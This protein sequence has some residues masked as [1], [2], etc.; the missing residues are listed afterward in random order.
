MVDEGKRRDAAITAETEWD[1]AVW[2]AIVIAKDLGT[3]E[4]LLRG[5]SVPAERIDLRQARRFGR[6]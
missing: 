2:R 3:C 4:A 1:R 5:E 6:R